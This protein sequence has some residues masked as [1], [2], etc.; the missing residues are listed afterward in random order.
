MVSELKWEIRKTQ[1]GGIR[2]IVTSADKMPNQIL[3]DM[4]AYYNKYRKHL[5]RAGEYNSIRIH[6]NSPGGNVNGA[7]GMLEALDEVGRRH[8]DMPVATLIEG[9]CNSAATMFLGVR[10]PTYITPGSGITVHRA[11]MVT[12]RRKKP[13]LWEK[14]RETFGR[15]WSDNLMAVTY[16]TACKSNGKKVTRK[17]VNEWMDNGRRFT[18]EEA[19]EVGLCA[20]IMTR[21]EFDRRAMNG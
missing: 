8:P 10:G 14:I 20:G 9:N 1:D 5:D 17:Q 2:I 3:R 18:A 7:L 13:G 15:G 4:R 21:T 6:V 11:R 16:R 12:Y 19:V